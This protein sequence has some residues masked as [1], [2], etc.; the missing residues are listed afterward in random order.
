MARQ[1][2]ELAVV[3][4]IGMALRATAPLF[5]MLARVYRE[6]RTIVIEYGARPPSGGVTTFTGDRETRRPMVRIG[7]GVIDTSVAGCARRGFAAIHPIA[8]TRQ[9]CRADMCTRE[10]ELCDGMVEGGRCPRVHRVA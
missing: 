10:G 2:G 7:G 8:V 5:A 9:A 4:T 3:R 6:P 1:A